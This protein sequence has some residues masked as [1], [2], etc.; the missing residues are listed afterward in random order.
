MVSSR[1][2]SDLYVFPLQAFDIDS[3]I[4][5]NVYKQRSASAMDIGSTREANIVATVYN[6]SSRVND[7][8]VH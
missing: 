2:S 1:R 7:Q 4:A 5:K 3:T 8:L 6:L